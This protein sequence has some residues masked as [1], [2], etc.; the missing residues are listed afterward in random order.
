MARKRTSTAKIATIAG[1][2]LA[3]VVVAVGLT[4][5]FGRRD[6]YRALPPFPVDAYLSGGN[7][8]SYD[9]YRI[10]GRVENVI[11]RS[12]ESGVIVAS[13]QPLDSKVRLPLFI[14]RT[15]GTGGVQLEQVL[16][17]KVTL[18]P[19]KEIRCLEFRQ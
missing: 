1:G 16:D 18:G 9:E 2:F 14:Q 7:L 10:K 5:A 17:F 13:V 11:Y 19:N 3:I 12:H 6:A 4:F 8:W 15:S